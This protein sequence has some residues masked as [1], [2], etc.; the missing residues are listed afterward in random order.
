MD[1]QPGTQW[2]YSNSGYILLGY[3]LERATGQPYEAF[4][5]EHIFAPLKMH[6][7][8]FDHHQSNLA[9]GYADKSSKAEFIDMSIPFAG[10]GLCST[11]EDLYLWDQALSSDRLIS[12][13]LL[14]K[15]FESHVV[16]P[17]ELTGYGYGW[18]I[19]W[20][21]NRR[22]I[23]HNG[24]I[25]GFVAANDRFPDD[26]IVV[27]VLSNQEDASIDKVVEYIEKSIFEEK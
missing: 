3:I 24:G 10:G 20:S 8:G 2:S 1:F 6:N 13:E 19:G 26:Q 17:Y 22:W 11:T 7:T 21:F 18:F 15:M 14:G 16:I 4:L 9:I 25:E 5:Q 23:G 12:Q 27:I